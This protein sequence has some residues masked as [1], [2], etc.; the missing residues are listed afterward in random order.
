MAVL[1]NKTNESSNRSALLR[2][3]LHPQP[4]LQLGTTGRGLHQELGQALCAQPGE[5]LGIN[6][7]EARDRGDF[8]AFGSTKCA[9]SSNIAFDRHAAAGLPKPDAGL[10]FGAQRPSRRPARPRYWASVA[11]SG[12]LTRPIV[13]LRVKHG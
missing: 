6:A 7:L 11:S 4:P 10:H 13:G 12:R 3:E 8:M 9:P 2:R 5:V 1:R